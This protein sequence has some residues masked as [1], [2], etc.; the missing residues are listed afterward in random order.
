MAPALESI[1][2]FI[3]S[4]LVIRDFS[5]TPDTVNSTIPAVDPD[6][7][8]HKEIACYSLPYGA[9]GFVSHALTYYTMFCLWYGRKPLW[10]FHPV[11]YTRLDLVLGTVSLIVSTTMAIVTLVRCRNSWQLLTIGV[12]KLTMSLVNSFTTITVARIITNG[13][14]KTKDAAHWLTLYVPGMVAGTVGVISLVT[15]HWDI[16]ALRI[17]SYCML[18]VFVFIFG[19]GRLVS[20][21]ADD[22][23][24]KNGVCIFTTMVS[25]VVFMFFAAFYSDWALGLMTGNLIG[26][27]SKDKIFD[28]F[29]I[30]SFETVIL[31]KLVPPNSTG[32]T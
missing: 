12:W 1:V 13:G 29:A 4:N 5:L 6:A 8:F 25:F 2:D 31:L 21:S 18:G 17:L 10:P 14:T 16:P 26:T 20:K 7:G 30:H 23:D 15:R 27:P 11:S 3:A 28:V 22:D 19:F 24:T 32:T 9:L